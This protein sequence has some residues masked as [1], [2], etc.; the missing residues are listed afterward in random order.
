MIYRN[1]SIE[2]STSFILDLKLNK[3]FHSHIPIEYDNNYTKTK[4]KDCLFY[5][6]S[7]R[8]WGEMNSIVAISICPNLVSDYCKL[9]K[10]KYYSMK[11][12]DWFNSSYSGWNRLF[13]RT[14]S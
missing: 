2:N 8:H 5:T 1:H 7:V 10:F 9:M 3:H 11:I 14:Y 6:G 12:L 13:L 4:I